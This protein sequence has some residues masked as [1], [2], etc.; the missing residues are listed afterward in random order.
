MNSSVRSHPGELAAGDV[1]AGKY[2]LLAPLGEGGMGC[3]WAAENL[4]TG[5]EVAA[6]LL[7]ASQAAS[8]VAIARF[9]REAHATAALSHRGI[10]RVFDLVDLDPV[11]GSLLLV[12]ELLRGRTLASAID[13]KGA[14]P[15]DETL[16]IVLPVL[17]ALAYAH[18]RGIVHRDLKPENVYLALD[19]DGQLLPK[20]VDFGV[21]KQLSARPI[22]LDGQLVG[23]L[24]YMSPE[25]T[26]GNPIDAQSDIF[27]VGILL[28]ECL[29][30]KNP[31]APPNGFG[32]D[33]RSAIRYALRCVH[34]VDPPPLLNVPPA[35]AAVVARALA[36]NASDRFASADE[37]AAAL[38]AA[39]S[40][41]GAF[42]ARA[43]ALA[44]KLRRSYRTVAVAALASLGLA[45]MSAARTRHDPL[46]ADAA[47]AYAKAVVDERTIAE[48]VD[49]TATETEPALFD[50]ATSSRVEAHHGAPAARFGASLAPHLD[51]VR[52]RV[53]VKWARN[54]GF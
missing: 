54:P 33:M 12:M 48:D 20:L 49:E 17:S 51:E 21:S 52:A 47:L 25:Q 3:V 41:A 15:V 35:L 40:S 11:Q 22:T 39:V 26:L 30:G 42:R 2:L 45:P 28:Y 23:T 53:A 5:A 6:K 34:E 44:P 13:E 46:R 8:P 27:A 43:R 37:L 4:A 29:S 19:P 9:R 10:V 16:A 31:F 50:A 18:A 1:L 36:R 7:H 32:R 24:S 38:R 14:L